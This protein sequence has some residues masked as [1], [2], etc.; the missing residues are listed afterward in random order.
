MLAPYTP[1]IAVRLEMDPAL[2]AV[3]R[4][5]FTTSRS[6]SREERKGVRRQ[7]AVSLERNVQVLVNTMTEAEFVMVR[8]I[9]LRGTAFAVGSEKTAGRS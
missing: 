5:R 9:G 7:P 3:D 8:G 4:Q 2:S 1:S 6:L